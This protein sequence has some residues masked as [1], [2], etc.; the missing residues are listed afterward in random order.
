[1]SLKRLELAGFKSFM[2][3]ICLDFKEGVTAIL[4]PNGCGKTNIVDAVRWVLGEQSARQLRSTKME[5]VIFNGTQLH[6]PVGQAVVNLTV[7]NER[8]RFP[9]DYSEITI[10][11][12]VYR[13]GISEY[14]I[15][16]NPCRLKDIKTLFADTGTGSHSYSVIEQEMMDYVL[17]D[18]H[19]ERKQMFEEAA[20]IVKYRIRREEAKRKLKLTE[21]DLVRLEDILE[22][23]GKQVRSLRYQ[24]G[25]TKRYRRLK[26]KIRDWELILLRKRLSG[27][28]SEKRVEE[29]RLSELEK[30]STEGSVSTSGMENEIE[31]MRLELVG[32]EKKNG[33]VQNDRY[34]LR[35][36]I[37][38]VEE[39]IIQLSERRAENER[40]IERNQK[41]IEEATGRIEGITERISSVNSKMENISGR[42]KAKKEEKLA[43]QEEYGKLAGETEEVKSK[44]I[45]LKQ[46]QLD[47]IQDQARLSNEI[48]HS[49][50]VLT[51]MDEQIREA[52]EEVLR[53]DSENGRILEEK[54]GL[55]AEADSLRER[56]GKIRE[57]RLDLIGR[58][59][60]IEDSMPGLEARLSDRKEAMAR[61][62]SRCELYRKMLEDYEGFPSGATRKAR[63]ANAASVPRVAMVGL[64]RK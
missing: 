36:K 40:R 47:F 1:V 8:G 41:E 60:K 59:K 4:G 32:L 45:G 21:Q 63:P 54:R 25:K 14:F 38:S 62:I 46:T 3:P 56:L 23:L 22:E 12:K 28:L 35:K 19:G 33:S 15:N 53:L 20:G 10:T 13:S 16:K 31:A 27:F 43:L 48:E 7:S 50:S 44:L 11:R 2:N 18:A 49:E 9:L 30:I 17:N 39:K 51:R 42:I 26:Q 6:K 64:T 61:S 34:D 37:Q 29:K 57:T 52:R 55:Q 58:K 5:N 24:V